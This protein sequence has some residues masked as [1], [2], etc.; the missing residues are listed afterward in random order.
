MKTDFILEIIGYTLPAL[1]TAALSYVY[2]SKILERQSKKDF[3][4]LE[5]L[6]KKEE[7]KATIDT[8]ALKL[9]ACERLVILIE[10][11]DLKKLVL[12]IEPVSEDKNTYQFALI[13]HIEQEFD[14]NISQQI[15]VTNELWQ[16]VLQTKNT[17]ISSVHQTAQHP[18][19]ANATALREVLLTENIQLQR[20]IEI[21]LSAIR[22]EADSLL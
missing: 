12:R 2:F 21:A 14:Y 7:N 9:Q 4:L 13:Q 16:I 17:I 20:K 18:S 22:L 8:T 19:V 10:R 1:T 11:I 5:Q 15:Y 3:Y 6:K